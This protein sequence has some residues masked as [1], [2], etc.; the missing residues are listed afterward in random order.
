M[1]EGLG[2]ALG[3]SAGGFITATFGTASVTARVGGAIFLLLSLFY[4]IVLWRPF[5]KR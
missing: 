4:L 5:W 3:P 1:V 2:F